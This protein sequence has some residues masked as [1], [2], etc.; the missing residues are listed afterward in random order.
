MARD[1]DVAIIGGGIVGL[2]NAWSAARQGRSVVL[3]ERE[4]RAEG[5]SVRNFGMVWPIGQTAGEIH[6]RSLRSRERWLELAERAGL[7]VNPCGSLHLARRPDELA[8]IEEFA[9]LAPALGFECRLLTPAETVAKSL[10]ARTAG[11]LGALWSPTELCIDPREAI[12]KL[13]GFLAEEYGVQ[14]RFGEAVTRI[15]DGRVWAGGKTWRAGR[16]V[17]CSG[18]DFR[19]LFPEE[20]AASGIRKCKLQM[21]RTSPQPGGWRLGPH[22]AGGLTLCHYTSFQECP[23]LPA[24]RDRVSRETPDFV[25]YGIHVMASQNGLGEVVIGDSHEYDEAI[26]PF[27]KPEIDRLILDYLR[28]MLELP[29]PTIVGRWHGVYAKHPTQPLFLAEPQPNTHIVS[30]TGGT[31]MTM[32]FGWADDLWERWEA[33]V[34]NQTRAV[35]CQA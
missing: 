25:K 31:G 20:F 9:A 33:G 13:P 27:D 8:V 10:G 30:A 14:L 29:D 17:V 2:A 4:N 1:V 34:T 22:L 23:S 19:T 7:W 18:A 15:D 3:F 21:M 28:D 35:A 26:S 16:V 24:L 5:A 6:R 12:A 11:L 32:S